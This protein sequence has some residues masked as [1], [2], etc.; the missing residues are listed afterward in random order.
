VGFTLRIKFVCL[1]FFVPE[2]VRGKGKMHVLMP[3]TCGNES[4][5][6]PEVEHHNVSLVYPFPGGR[7]DA[8]GHLAKESGE[9]P[10]REYTEMTGWAL[11]LGGEGGSATT[12]L[13]EEVVDVTD[14][15]GFVDPILLQ[16]VKHAKVASHV[17]L[18][19]GEIGPFESAAVWRYNGR[20]LDIAQE[21]LWTM[22][23]EGDGLSWRR[24]RLK[25][26]GEAQKDGDVEELPFVPANGGVVELEI[27]HTTPAGFPVPIGGYELPHD[28]VAGHF[29]AFYTLFKNPRNPELP[30]WM[31]SV[32]PLT[33][34][35][36]SGRLS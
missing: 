24:T 15:A 5:D 1:C 13:H 31:H 10:V 3:A 7:L 14:N 28:V 27:H 35:G 23:L 36:A 33:C 25:P 18:T 20:P 32:R 11:T 26:A 30:V 12:T 16:D 4:P 8:Q 6:A 21:I 2:E 29:A 17:T 9:P 22:S 34:M 19:A